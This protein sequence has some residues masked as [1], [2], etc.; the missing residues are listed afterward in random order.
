MKERQVEKITPD[1]VGMELKL[2]CGWC[3]IFWDGTKGSKHG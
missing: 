1:M 2:S 3:K